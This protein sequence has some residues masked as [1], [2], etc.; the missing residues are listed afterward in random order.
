VEVIN[1][2]GQT[3]ASQ[4]VSGS[5]ASVDISQLL[6]GVYFVKIYS[7]KEVYVKKFLKW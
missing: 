3:I 1:F 5:S 4:P 2:L 6:N 7:E